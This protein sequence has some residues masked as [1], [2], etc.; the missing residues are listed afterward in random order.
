MFSIQIIALYNSHRG[1]VASGPILEDG[2]Q[3]AEFSDYPEQIYCTPHF[4]GGYNDVYERFRT[5]ACERF[6][7]EEN[8]DMAISEYAR[9]LVTEAL[10]RASSNCHE[11]L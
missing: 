10:D 1:I 5:A 4:Y 11:D 3:I 6:P 2:R 8:E 7:D 9:Q